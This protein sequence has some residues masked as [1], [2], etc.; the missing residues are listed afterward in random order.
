M[1]LD[2]LEELSRPTLGLAFH[3]GV[4][5]D[6]LA[7]GALLDDLLQTVEGAAA[8]EQ[9]VV[10]VHLDELLMGVLPAALRRHVGHGALQDL[11]QCLLHALAGHVPGDGGVLALAGDLVDLVH[12]DD[13]VLGQ[14]HV[15]IRRLQKPQQDVL[16]VVAYITGFGEGGSVGDGE[17]NL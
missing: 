1:G 15:E 3:H 10:G 6:A 11:Q 17:G 9:N 2:L 8:D 4:E 14:L 12:I 13:A 7:V 16:H 5:A